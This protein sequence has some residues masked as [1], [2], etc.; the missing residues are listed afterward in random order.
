MEQVLRRGFRLYSV[1]GG[2]HAER[3][4]RG[5]DGYLQRGVGAADRGMEGQAGR[6]RPQLQDEARRHPGVRG[7]DR[8]PSCLHRLCDRA[9]AGRLHCGADQRAV[10]GHRRDSRPNSVQAG[11]HSPHDAGHS[12][13]LRGQRA[14]RHVQHGR[15]GSA[16]EH[17][18]RPAV[19]L[20]RRSGLGH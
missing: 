5:A 12:D 7:H 14:H 17:D 10:P 6:F 1:C 16:P 18:A 8:R 3:S 11:A 4:G 9:A 19:R 20:R 15:H 13:L 2:I